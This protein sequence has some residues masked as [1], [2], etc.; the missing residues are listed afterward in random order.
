MRVL[1]ADDDP[2][3]LR[4]LSALLGKMGHE[5][6]VTRDGQE[7]WEVFQKVHV[8]LVISDWLMPRMSGVELCQH[9]RAEAR[10]NYSYIVL[11]TTLSS[12]EHVLEGFRAG[13]DDY[14]TK[15]VRIEELERRVI[16]ADRTRAGMAAKVEAALR[17]AVE[18]VQ[19]AEDKPGPAL[20]ETVR[21]IGNFYRAEGAYTK[22]RAFLRRQMGIVTETNGGEEELAKLRRELQSLEGLEDAPVS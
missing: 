16:V 3:C 15:P 13:A 8:P 2:T 11:V 5:P 14:M 6:L 9:I 19:S 4:L 7:A 18:T 20:L 21:S 1:I 10:E 12:D 22:A 17:K